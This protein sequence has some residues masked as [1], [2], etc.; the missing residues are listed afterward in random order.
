MREVQYVMGELDT[1]S[2]GLHTRC[3]AVLRGEFR[4]ERATIYFDYVQHV[5]GL[6]VQAV[7]ALGA[8]GRAVLGALLIAGGLNANARGRRARCVP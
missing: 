3:P 8:A 5:F 4:I 1:G 7:P 2:S 6:P